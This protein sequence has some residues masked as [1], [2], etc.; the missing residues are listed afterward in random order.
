MKP[1]SRIKSVILEKLRK[2]IIIEQTES[3]ES[4]MNDDVEKP[5]DDVKDPDKAVKL[6]NRMDKMIKMKKNNTFTI[7]RKQGEIFKKFKTNN[8]FLSAVKAFNISKATINFKTGI[9]EFINMYPKMEKSCTSLYYL[10]NNFRI[11]KEVF[12][13]NATEFQKYFTEKR[14]RLF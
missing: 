8:K 13:E 14:L 6:I 5:L 11:I 9:V 2:S 1:E 7:N 12:H 4:E 3:E 10:K